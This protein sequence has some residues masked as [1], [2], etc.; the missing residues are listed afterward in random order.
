M[1]EI[2]IV[3][4]IVLRRVRHRDRRAGV[5]AVHEGDR[6]AGSNAQH[7]RQLFGDDRP[8]FR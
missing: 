3:K 1:A 7:L 8:F 5:V 2:Q 6:A 4:N